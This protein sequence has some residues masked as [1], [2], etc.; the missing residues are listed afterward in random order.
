MPAVPDEDVI[1]EEDLGDATPPT[2]DPNPPHTFDDTY[3]VL[4]DQL[5]WSADG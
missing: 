1:E 2:P 5:T 4:S 3:L